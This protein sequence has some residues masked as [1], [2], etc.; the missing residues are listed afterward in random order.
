MLL[1]YP[2]YLSH[3]SYFRIHSACTSP[4]IAMLTD[5]ASVQAGFIKFAGIQSCAFYPRQMHKIILAKPHIIILPDAKEKP[6]LKRF[7][8][9]NIH[10]F[11]YGA[12]PPNCRSFTR[13]A[14]LS[15]M[16]KSKC[17][18]FTLPVQRKQ[19]LY[20]SCPVARKRFLSWYLYY[21]QNV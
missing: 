12:L 18:V 13:P 4:G 20:A 14:C 11:H 15:S 17:K 9:H 6:S 10:W 19:T 3:N 8:H 1:F 5:N 21:T 7:L 16:L 2:V